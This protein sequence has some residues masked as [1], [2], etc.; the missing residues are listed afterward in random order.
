MTSTCRRN[1]ERNVRRDALKE[2]GNHLQQSWWPAVSCQGDGTV[3]P[4]QLPLRRAAAAAEEG[5][6]MGEEAKDANTCSEMPSYTH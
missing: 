5:A 1:R 2:R 6:Q 4:E 3:A